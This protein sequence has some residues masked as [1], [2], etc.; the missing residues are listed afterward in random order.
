MAENDQI[1][2]CTHPGDPEHEA[3]TLCSAVREAYHHTLAYTVATF[4]PAHASEYGAIGVRIGRAQVTDERQ[5]YV[6]PLRDALARLATG[7]LGA[8]GRAGDDL[9]NVTELSAEYL[10]RFC[11][12]VVAS[13]AGGS[14]PSR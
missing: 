11:Q 1:E 3:G 4:T 2:T 5:D 6:V 10:D 13:L 8:G 7:A 14:H 9:E 12:P